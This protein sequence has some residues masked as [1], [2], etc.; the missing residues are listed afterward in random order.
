MPNLIVL[1]TLNEGFYRSTVANQKPVRD[2]KQKN[3]KR[4]RTYRNLL[5]E[6]R[7]QAFK[8]FIRERRVQRGLISPK[9][10]KKRTMPVIPPK[11]VFVILKAKNKVIYDRKFVDYKNRGLLQEYITFD[12]KILS[13]RKTGITTKQQR[14]LTKAIKTARIL[15]LLPFV[16]KEKG[17]FR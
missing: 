8:D 11:S 5:Q 13:K 1:K 15:G 6:K 14:Y 12:G 7:D 16:K 9:R 2:I 4:R 3:Q 10:D 17:L